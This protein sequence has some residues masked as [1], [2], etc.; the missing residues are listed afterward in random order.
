MRLPIEDEWSSQGS[1]QRASSTRVYAKSDRC[2]LTAEEDRTP[3]WG[4]DKHL[5]G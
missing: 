5:E 4:E 1:K 3:V 2:A